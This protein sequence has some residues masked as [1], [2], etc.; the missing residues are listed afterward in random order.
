MGPQAEAGAGA[1]IH[2][3]GG[4]HKGFPGHG[5]ADHKF[6][7]PSAQLQ[8][9]FK[10]LQA[11]EKALQ[12]EIP[13]SLTAAV[14]ADQTVIEKA[15]SALTPA[16]RKA[17]HGAGPNEMTPGT[18]PTSQLA[19]DL[20]SAGISSSQ[21]STI[22]ADFKNLKSAY[23]TTDPN[24]QTKLAAD[25]AAIVKDGGPAFPFPGHPFGG[26]GMPGRI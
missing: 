1:H 7:P 5:L 19:A 6:A 8:A 11:D 24:L 25:Q 2:R 21:A 3:F 18:D 22:V 17:L 16:E 13:S 15:F 20:V 12:A 14:R 4:P 10:T 23:T 26:P 9:D